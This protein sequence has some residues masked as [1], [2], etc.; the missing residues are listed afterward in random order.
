M[1]KREFL[2]TLRAGLSGIPQEDREERLTFYSEMIDDR[3]EEGLSEEEAVRGI[4][5]P[6]GIIKQIITETPLSKLVKERIRPKKGFRIWEIILLVLGS[7]LWFAFL[8]VGASLIFSGYVVI[9]SL[10]IALWAVFVSLIAGTAAAAA[11]GIVFI[12]RGNTLSGL[13]MISGAIFC[14]GLSIFLF[15]ACLGVSKGAVALTRKIFRGIKNRFVRKEE[16]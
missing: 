7:P 2:E 11:A 1:N 3:M 15:F 4:G 10:V 13:A 16:I 8:I 5:D 12:F 6:D 9:W 14:A